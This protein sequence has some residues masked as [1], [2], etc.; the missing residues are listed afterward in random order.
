MGATTSSN[1]MSCPA[2]GEKTLSNWYVL[3]LSALGPMDNSTFFP[4][5]PSVDTTTP[6]FSRTSLS[7]RP[8]QRTTTLMLVSSA[9]SCSNSRSFRFILPLTERAGDFVGMDMTDPVGEVL[10]VNVGV[11][12]CAREG[13]GRIDGGRILL[14]FAASDGRMGAAM[15]YRQTGE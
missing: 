10:P 7:F 8:L 9:I 6:L 14:F 15:S 12:V 4:L 3:L 1:T 11:A 5:T 13:G 2:A